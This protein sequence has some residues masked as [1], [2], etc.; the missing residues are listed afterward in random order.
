MTDTPR[1]TTPDYEV[2]ESPDF[3]DYG[4]APLTPRA[5]WPTFPKKAPKA[6]PAPYTVVHEEPAT[7]PA[8]HAPYAHSDVVAYQPARVQRSE[9]TFSAG[10]VILGIAIVASGAYAAVQETRR[11]R[12]QA[13]RSETP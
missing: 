4:P 6:S 7:L 5:S 12:V 2:I 8:A 13:R 9:P 11:K 1:Y 10:D 3:N